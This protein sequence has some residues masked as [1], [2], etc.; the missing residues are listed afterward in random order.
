M[1]KTNIIYILNEANDSLIKLYIIIINKDNV[2]P[3]MLGF[4]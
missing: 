3:C 1:H 2:I 4:K